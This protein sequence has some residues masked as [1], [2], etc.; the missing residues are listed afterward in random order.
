MQ[1]LLGNVL[2]LP[3]GELQHGFDTLTRLVFHMLHTHSYFVHS[4]HYCVLT[5]RHS[6][7][8]W[9]LFLTVTAV[10][11]CLKVKEQ[12]FRFKLDLFVNP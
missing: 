4:E 11:P 3:L 9:Q 1:V 2:L 5:I 6:F 7:E 10:V 12:H 8:V